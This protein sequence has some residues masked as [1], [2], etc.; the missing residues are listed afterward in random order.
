MALGFQTCIADP[1]IVEVARSFQLIAGLEGFAVLFLGFAQIAYL[2]LEPALIAHVS[3]LIVSVTRK[4]DQ[5]LTAP[6]N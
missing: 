3:C 2:S 6:F 5:A 1:H 4:L